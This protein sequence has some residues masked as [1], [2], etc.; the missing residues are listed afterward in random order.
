MSGGN[1]KCGWFTVLRDDFS[2]SAR[3][4]IIY[5]PYLV[6]WALFIVFLLLFGYRFLRAASFKKAESEADSDRRKKCWGR[7]LVERV[8]LEVHEEGKQREPLRL[9][10]VT[11][12]P[13]PTH[14]VAAIALEAGKR[15]KQIKGKT[16]TDP[17]KM[18][19]TLG[20]VIEPP[21]FIGMCL[22]SVFAAWAYDY[23]I[24][25]SSDDKFLLVLD[26]YYLKMTI[27]LGMWLMQIA[28]L[29]FHYA[30]P[31][32]KRLNTELLLPFMY[33]AG[34][35]P[36]IDAVASM[37]ACSYDDET[38]KS[39]LK[40]KPEI[41]CWKGQHLTVGVIA[42]LGG[43]LLY[44]GGLFYK[45]H[46]IKDVLWAGGEARADIPFRYDE[47]FSIVLC[48][49]FYVLPGTS[50][51][52]QD[53]PKTAGSIFFLCYTFL[54][55]Q[56]YQLQPCQGCGSWAN[57]M[58]FVGFSSGALAALFVIITT[59]FKEAGMC[60]GVQYLF[61][62]FMALFAVLG[63]VGWKFNNVRAQMYAIPNV[64]YQE[65]L[66]SEK[67]YVR[68]VATLSL[69]FT[70]FQGLAGSGA[71]PGL[72]NQLH[73][74]LT[75]LKLVGIGSKFGALTAAKTAGGKQHDREKQ[76]VAAGGRSRTEKLEGVS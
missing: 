12:S 41:E 33:N 44:V 5:G 19:E 22:R 30:G 75:K 46:Q 10:I 48:M 26:I 14:C 24:F 31:K 51:M 9:K 69:S 40:L 57:N 56:S 21:F 63:R 25:L 4:E 39:F 49:A 65:L 54:Y 71:V 42:F 23:G 3:E 27:M 70:E 58:R 17:R 59:I 45:N 38:E 67:D 36:S 62:I 35:M 37:I 28:A 16:V 74:L 64:G 13:P 1:E 7:L 34:F 73:G 66:T 6:W 53:S 47:T 8:D 55:I 29:S 61:Y 52:L 43:L 18:I 76:N 32:F 15:K 68:Q 11:P 50:V 2:H 72:V 20:I 60:E